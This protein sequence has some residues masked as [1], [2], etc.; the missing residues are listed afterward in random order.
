[1][2]HLKIIS[3]YISKHFLIAFGSVLSGI[4]GLVLLFDTIELMR[5]ASSK[6]HIH[7][8]DVAQMAFF[9]MPQMIH[10]ILPFSVII[11]AMIT[12]WKLTKSQEL[13]IV[14]AVGISA[15]KFLTPVIIVTFLIGA[16][17][18]TALNPLASTMYLTYERMQDRLDLRHKNPLLFSEQGL[19]LREVKTNE[20]DEKINSVVHAE[21][22]QFEHGKLM[23]YNVSIIETTMKNVFSSRIHAEK[24]MLDNG[25]FMLENAW[26]MTPGNP[27]KKIQSMNIPTNLTLNKI[28]EKFASPETLSF[29]ELPAFIKFFE[30]SGFSALT[31]KLHFAS[32]LISPIFLCAM[33][34]VAAVFTLNPNHR[35]GGV[36]SKIVG[37]VMTSFGLYFFSK[38]TYAL[39]LS[40]ALPISLAAASPAIISILICATI[41]FHQEDG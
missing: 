5:R 28:E 3:L 25:Y 23:L 2:Q 7:F 10:V 31:H 22:L 36:F 20:K 29:W 41:L 18:I 32:L 14:R 27:S 35:K 38:L 12:F 8:T 24:G 13:V 33:V 11:G 9:K 16:A 30:A 15:W 1:M 40:S 26:K 37:G 4:M 21:D 19:W 34:L 17:N 6:E 39:G